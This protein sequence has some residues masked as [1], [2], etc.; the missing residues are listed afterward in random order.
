MQGQRK[1]ED[2][3]GRRFGILTVLRRGPNY[4]EPSG[5][6]RA[7]W[8]CVCDCGGTHTATGHAMKAGRIQSCGC[9]VG[10]GGKTHGKSYSRVYRNWAAMTQRATNPNS[11]HFASYGGRGIT[12]CERWTDF[13]NFLADMGEP[14]PGMTLERIDNDKG[15]SPDNC[16]WA[17]RK[18]QA[19]NRRTSK[20]LTYAGKTLTFAQWG[21]V[22]GLG[23]HI[24]AGRA[25]SGWPVDDILWK[26]IQ[27][28]HKKSMGAE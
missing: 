28:V 22:T 6:I 4:A 25:A 13:A 5:A 24:I 26:P 27:R 1:L 16:R 7:Q 8:L 19:Q 20:V 2:L 3:T 23:R 18:E 15:Y 11:T 14:E 17:S 10:K 21:D 12:I 9:L